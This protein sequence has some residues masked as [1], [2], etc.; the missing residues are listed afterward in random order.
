[1]D[2]KQIISL[3]QARSEQAIEELSGKYGKLCF[4][5]ANN[6]LNDPHDAEECL[7]D[8][9]F[10]VWNCI[11]PQNPDP[12]RAFLCRIVRNVAL[13]KLRANTAIKRKRNYEI[14]LSEL[15]DCIPDSSFDDAIS[16]CELAAQIN[17]FLSTLGQEDRILFLKR[18]WFAESLPTIAQLFGITEHN[19]AVRLSRIRG[20][21]R[22]YLIERGY[23]YHEQQ[24]DK[25][26]YG[27][28]SR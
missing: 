27:H 4:Q 13:K 28:G 23:P 24:N 25:N 1:M 18:Y 3:F 26:C 19:A 11:P 22:K 14:S 20:K 5:I 15:G 7:N 2:D 10:A 6:I 12:L 16:L 8:T 21:L 9:Y 17:T